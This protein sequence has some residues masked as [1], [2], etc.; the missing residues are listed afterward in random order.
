MPMALAF[1]CAALE[2]IIAAS[3]ERLGTDRVAIVDGGYVLRL[4]VAMGRGLWVF[5]RRFP[6]WV[7]VSLVSMYSYIRLCFYRYVLRDR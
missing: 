2:A 6:M 3:R 7:C 1:S 4:G 5:E